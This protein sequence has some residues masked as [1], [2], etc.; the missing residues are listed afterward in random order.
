VTEKT[1][2]RAH[3][4]EKKVDRRRDRQEGDQSGQES[5]VK[6]PKRPHDPF[7]LLIVKLLPLTIFCLNLNIYQ[8]FIYHAYFFAHSSQI[9]MQS[10]NSMQFTGKFFK[11]HPGIKK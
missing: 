8:F 10:R 3:N 6:A 11:N 9:M 1:L 7:I 2:G 4:P 5:F